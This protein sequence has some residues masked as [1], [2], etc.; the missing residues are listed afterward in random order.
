MTDQ[1]VHT[2]GPAPSA[3]AVDGGGAAGGLLGRRRELDRLRA[4][5][6]HAGPDTLSG[7]PSARCRVLLVAGRPGSG[8]TALAEEFARRVAADYPDGILRARLSDPDGTPVPTER[9]A[10]DLLRAL[11]AVRGTA[12]GPAAAS[13]AGAGD[14]ELA[15]A[16]RAALADRR[17][18]L[19]LDD[20]AAPEQL[21]GLL[22][23]SRGCLVL[24][25]SRGPMTGISDVRPCTLEGLDTAAAVALLEQR[26]GDT[27]RITVDP[28]AA[29]ALAE[30]CGGRPAALALVGGWLAAHPMASVAEAARRFA[31]L[32][33]DLPGGAADDAHEPEDASGRVPGGHPRRPADGPPGPA[34]A[35]V[36][37][38]RTRPAPVA[39]PLAR[40]F[41]L[42]HGSLPPFAA[43]FLRLLALAPAGLAD[44]H[45]AAALA[46]CRADEA[47]ATLEAF[48]GLGLLR[49]TATPGLYTV[50]GCLA[51]FLAAV[52]EERERPQ[53]VRLARARV[54]ERSVRLLR[55]C[56]AAAEP[57]GSPA[58]RAAAGLPRA[59][60]FESRAAAA[61][62]LGPRLPGL[63]AATRTAVADGELDTLARRLAAALAGAL[64]AHAGPESA[65]PEMYRLHELLLPVTER[66][67]L[68]GERAAILLDL[69]DLDAHAGRPHRALT[70][71][72]AALEAARADGGRG[73]DRSAAAA[74][75][76]LESLGDTYAR[77][78]DDRRAGDWYGRALALCQTRGEPAD[79]ARLHGLI[80]AAYLREGR[81]EEALRAWRACAAACR[82]LRDGE[83]YARALEEVARVQEY[84]GRAEEARRTR[85]RALR[86]GRPGTGH[87]GGGDGA[88]SRPAVARWMLEEAP[89][90]AESDSRPAK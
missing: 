20:V 62:W 7:R 4:D 57:P 29:E 8:R 85:R 66:R 12:G 27:P 56:R 5:A 54:L 87:G 36:P 13:V 84:A 23:D 33:D 88:R 25:V 59:L 30:A 37:G 67:G 76:A 6:E 47:A 64:T 46:G 51:P 38:P 9:T 74:A 61:A 72:R 14:A 58:R 63:R 24:A 78:G 35:A 41:H 1:A 31:A 70:R 45:T 10:R 42:V 17:V 26:A 2:G 83:S 81:W 11:P 18:L 28:R 82:R 77:L 21:H 86:W 65:A 80:G 16:L 34:R 50:P 3:G 32:P 19:V 68:H 15:E 44:A 79:E 60:R 48:T 75:R 43:R 89:R 40:A 90:A 49:T 52:L 55:S 69:G 71:Y 53:D 39:R 73:G 22:P